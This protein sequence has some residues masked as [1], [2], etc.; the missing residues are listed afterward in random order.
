V[1]AT[2]PYVTRLLVRRPLDPARFNG[3]VIVEWLNVTSGF[4]IDIVAG[5]LWRETLRSGYAYVGVSTQTASTT[6]LAACWACAA[7]SAR[8]SG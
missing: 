1:P 7:R 5:E 4:D 3:T 8:R 2:A 6:S